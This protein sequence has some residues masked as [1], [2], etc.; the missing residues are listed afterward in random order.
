VC[1][2][3]SRRPNPPRLRRRLSLRPQCGRGSLQHAHPRGTDAVS[4]LEV[5][6]TAG[7]SAGCRAGKAPTESGDL[8]DHSVA[9]A[10][11]LP[12]GGFSVGRAHL[13]RCQV[14][15]AHQSIHAPDQAQQ[16]ADHPDHR[17]STRVGRSHALLTSAP[18]VRHQGEPPRRPQSPPGPIYPTP[19]RRARMPDL[20]SPGR[21][22][23]FSARLVAAGNPA[24]S[25][26][27]ASYRRCGGGQ[28][29]GAPVSGRANHSRPNQRWTRDVPK[30]DLRS[31]SSVDGPIRSP[32]GVTPFRK[33]TS[34][35]A[36]WS[37]PNSM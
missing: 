10:A 6:G 2:Q 15:A 17:R 31:M 28:R 1:R 25:R 22:R 24:V 3:E 29:R 20:D 11:T 34:T 33:Y 9:S 13:R 8:P 18:N 7:D 36:I 27:A 35:I 30:S 37:W 23:H 14:W 12:A 32:C 19:R 26:L 16:I 21:V 5:Q 4:V